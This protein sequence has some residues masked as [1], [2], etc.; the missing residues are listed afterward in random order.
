MQRQLQKDDDGYYEGQ[1]L[2]MGDRLAPEEL[3]V[4]AREEEGQQTRARDEITEIE[5][6]ML[7][8]VPDSKLVHKVLYKDA[9]LH[10]NY[11]N[12]NSQIA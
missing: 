1:A 11:N 8:L 2:V 3:K 4:H 5:K 12:T 6:L 7:V 9:L 10:R